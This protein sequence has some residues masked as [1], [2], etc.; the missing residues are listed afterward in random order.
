[1]VSTGGGLDTDRNW[2]QKKDGFFLPG[3]SLAGLFKGKLLSGLKALRDAGK[4]CYEGNAARYRNHYE[5]Q[6]L[7][8]ACYGKH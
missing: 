6:E 8:N 3:K 1:M 2:R 4:L 5:Y 7:L